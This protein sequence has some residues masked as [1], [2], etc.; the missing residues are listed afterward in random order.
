MGITRATLSRWRKHP[1]SVD[2]VR[3]LGK[4]EAAAIY[5]AFYWDA[6]GCESLPIGEDLIAFDSAVNHGTRRA[7]TWVHNV[8]ALSPDQR[9]DAIAATRLAF[10]K[11]LRTWAVYGRGWSAR[12]K[13]CLA[14]ANR[15]QAQ[16]RGVHS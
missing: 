7:L 14:L 12:G 5:R 10:W 11:S 8:A 13:A 2:D 9:D 16:A 6:I 3:R 4:P 15:M 1:V